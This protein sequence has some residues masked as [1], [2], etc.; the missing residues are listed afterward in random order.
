MAKIFPG[1]SSATRVFPPSLSG[2][3][4]GGGDLKWQEAISVNWASQSLHDFASDATVDIDGIEWKCLNN[5][6]AV[7]TDGLRIDGSAGLRIWPAGDEHIWDQRVDSPIV[8]VLVKDAVGA[9]TT[10][11]MNKHA[12]CFQCTFTATQDISNR[13][14]QIGAIAMNSEVGT[15]NSNARYLNACGYSD[16]YTTSQYRSIRTKSAEAHMS[17]Y[18][19]A[20]T[21]LADR[22]FFQLIIWPGQDYIGT[23]VGSI[24]SMPGSGDFPDPNDWSPGLTGALDLCTKSDGS[25]FTLANLRVGMQS[26]AQ[27][28]GTTDPNPIFTKC[29]VMYA[30]MV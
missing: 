2:G 9:K 26:C 29:R 17:K 1:G 13:W 6:A 28:T 4:G 21:A 22:N 12:V 23:I 15:S 16:N 25:A 14:D 11:A 27:A 5:G 3:G 19:T 10:Y 20:D 7:Q 30:E 24:G 8:S 18:P